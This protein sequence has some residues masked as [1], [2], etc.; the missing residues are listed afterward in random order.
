MNAHR[1]FRI[2]S[3]LLIVALC[4]GGIALYSR[5]RPQP[6]PTVLERPQSQA[7]TPA[8]PMFVDDFA[9]TGRPFKIT[10]YL[11]E[12][13]PGQRATLILPPGLNLWKGQT[14]QRA[15]PAPDQH[16]NYSALSWS[17]VAP[18]EGKYR[19]RVEVPGLGTASE[20]VPVPGGWSFGEPC[21]SESGEPPDPP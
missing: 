4:V 6:L 16:K 20:M 8:M 10:L 18:K 15:I 7:E 2:L 14:A 12:P 19:I 9:K 11:R 13:Q 5:T 17:V 1:T 3:L 21:W